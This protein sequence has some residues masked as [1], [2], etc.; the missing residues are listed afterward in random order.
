MAVKIVEVKRETCPAARFIGKKYD[1]APNWGEW[2]ENEW[3]SILEKT[4]RLPINGNAYIGAIHIVD[5]MPEYWI[6]MFFSKDVIVPDA[7]DYVDIEPMEY[8]VFYLYDKENSSDFY[9]MDTHDMCLEELKALGLKR[10]EDDW[11][12]ERYNC[13]RFTTPDEKGNVILDYAVS[14]ED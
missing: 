10:K 4:E 9:T 12:F 3:F 5:G 14:I 13:P 2:W 1:K 8:A 11:C 7:F 6:G